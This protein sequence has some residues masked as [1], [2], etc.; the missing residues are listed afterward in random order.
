MEQRKIEGTIYNALGSFLPR[1]PTFD[2]F[3]KVIYIIKR[4]NIIYQS[5][6]F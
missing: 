5:Q 2:S 3:N 4:I 1:G 6:N